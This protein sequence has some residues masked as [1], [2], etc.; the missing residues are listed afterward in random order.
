MQELRTL[1]SR[2]R[3]KLIEN[4]KATDEEGCPLRGTED[5]VR[6]AADRAFEL[7][8]A[9]PLE[10]IR[11]AGDHIFQI[12]TPTGNVIR[13]KREVVDVRRII[14]H[15]LRVAWNPLAVGPNEWRFVGY[16]SHEAAIDA[17]LVLKQWDVY[18]AELLRDAT[19]APP[20]EKDGSDYSSPDN[21][22]RDL[23]VYEQKKAGRS[24]KEIKT[25]LERLSLSRG[26]EP[27][28]S[29]T[30]IN[31]AADKIA[32][33]HAWPMIRGRSGRPRTT[34]E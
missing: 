34:P 8:L 26:W 30:S 9:P 25:E 27:L 2:I 18:L 29:T 12:T 17:I 5:M 21:Y 31:K 22:E 1:L 23:W 32:L 28:S 16:Y 24:N 11:H 13:H 20:A 33:Y 15:A 6:E 14:G 7:G 3:S 19:P 4:R 10:Y